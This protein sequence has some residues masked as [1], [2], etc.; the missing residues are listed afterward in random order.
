VNGTYPANGDYHITSGSPAANTPV[1]TGSP[2]GA[3][4]HDIDAQARPNGG[5]FDIGADELY[6]PT[7]IA[8]VSPQA[9]AFGA[10]AVNATSA[11]QVVT[12]SNTGGANLVITGITITGQNASQYARTT[13]CPING[14][15]L[16]PAATCTISVTFTPTSGGP[17]NQATLS[18]S[19][20][21]VPSP[22]AVGLT[23]SGAQ[24]A[25][26]FTSATPPGTLSTAPFL[27]TSL[28]FGNQSGPVS[29]TV[30]VT[31]SGQAPL[32]ITTVNVGNLFGTAFSIGPSTCTNATV[33]VGG[34][35][36]VVV[37]FNAPTNNSPRFG[38]LTL[39]DNGTGS[40]QALG[41]GGS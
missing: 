30:T 11:P 6:G 4:D 7:P 25:V 33:A 8:A 40:P 3:P 9:L 2:N 16:A 5:G 15:G 35:C 13:T 22:Q 37:R 12:L 19:D 14:P 31:N 41:L 29:S 20:N 26:T 34:T 39:N 38:T 36:T 24:G 28:G 27:G 1:N 21:A 23:G 17:K 32:A 10:Q 18:I